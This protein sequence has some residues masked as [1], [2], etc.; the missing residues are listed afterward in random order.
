MLLCFLEI[1][2]A[3]SIKSHQLGLTKHE[4]S[5]ERTKRQADVGQVQERTLGYQDK[6]RVG[7]TVFPRKDINPKNIHE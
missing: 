2:E 7:Q 4:L 3:A 1:A 5:K 6:L